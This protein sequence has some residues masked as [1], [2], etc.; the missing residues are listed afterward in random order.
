MLCEFALKLRF[1]ILTILIFLVACRQSPAPEDMLPVKTVKLDEAAAY[2]A[3]LGLAYLKQGNRVRA[4]HK[5]LQ[6]LAQAPNAPNTNASMAYFMEK[7]G[8]L[9]KARSYYQKAIL[10]SNSAGTQLNNYGAFLCRQGDFQH[11]EAYFLKAAADM[12]YEHTAGALE[13]AGLC[14]LGIPDLIKAKSYFLKALEEDPSR[15]QSL[16]ELVNIET[17]QGR[18]DQALTYLQKYQA[19]AL[20]DR[21]LL[22]MAANVAEKAGKIELARDYKDRLRRF[23]DITG[24]MN[25]YNN[26]SG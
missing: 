19:I 13:N 14:V 8:E 15:E 26:T 1:I 24:E 11:A 7:S 18:F 25:E 3:Q 16:Y 21:T 4:K 20:S 9:D 2:N 22:G 5:L 10:T 23:T 12:Q 17:S 6:A